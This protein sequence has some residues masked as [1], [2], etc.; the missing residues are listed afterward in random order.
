M[1]NTEILMISYN[2][3]GYLRKSLPRLLDT[4]DDETS[5]WLWHNGTHAETTELAHE[6]ATDAR[7]ARFHHSRDNVGLRA[8]TNWLWSNSTAEFLGKVDDD[9]LMPDGWV[10]V[11]RDAHSAN[12][13]FGIVGCWHFPLE[14]FDSALASWKIHEY[15]GDH[16]L[17]VN[18]WIGGS[19][20]LMK[21]GCVEA[22]GLL[23]EKDTFTD[24]CVRIASHGWVNGWRY[25]LIIQDHMDDPRSPNCGLI[26][27][28]DFGARRP[29]STRWRGIESID[30]W[31]QELRREARRL[32]QASIDIKDYQ[33]LRFFRRR[34]GSA[35]RRRLPGKTAAAYETY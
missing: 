17:M 22:E 18:H 24:Y 28:E 3:P 2:R 25:P 15:S 11:L 10:S 19:G 26:T 13:S 1:A 20:Y 30:E 35:L 12:P 27:S 14:D 7:V 21:R 34:V 5:V 16:A 31:D 33:G 8:P 23:G 9:C 6:Y 4:C 32:Q 29:L